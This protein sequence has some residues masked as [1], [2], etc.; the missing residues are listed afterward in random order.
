MA[1]K[2]HLKIKTVEEKYKVYS[3]DCFYVV[4]RRWGFIKGKALGFT[5]QLDTPDFKVSDC[6]LSK[7]K[8]SLVQNL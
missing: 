1:S 4:K 2:G 5:K 3:K 7:W 6:W 8:T